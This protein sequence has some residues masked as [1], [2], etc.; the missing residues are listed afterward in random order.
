M[1]IRI[2]VVGLGRMGVVHAFHAR[3]IAAADSSFELAAVVDADAQRAAKMAGELG[4][5]HYFSSVENLAA[6]GVADAA[7]VATPTEMHRAHTQALIAAGMRVLLEKPLTESLDSD[8]SF[9][10]WLDQQAPDAVMLGFQRRF[11][12]PL[13]EA[14]KLIDEGAIGRPFKI[15]SVLEDSGPLPD[16][17]QS[18]GLLTDMA[19]HNVDEVRWLTG[20]TPERAAAIG[21]NLSSH[22]LTTAQEDHDEALLLLWFQQ[23]LAARIEVSRNHRPGYRIETQIFGEEGAVHVGRFR[24]NKLEVVLEAFGRERPLAREAHP[25]R[26]YENGMPEFVD[27][28]GAAY[29]AELAAFVECC[30][31][32]APFPV[33]HR[34]GLA[35]MQ[36]IEA[37][38]RGSLT[39][40]KID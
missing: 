31:E 29:Q 26:A 32:D 15:V 22:K 34:D 17:Y 30:R 10:A 40:A 8:R 28:Y 23:D 21:F 1:K 39:T 6:A 12:A 18:S 36:V 2:A 4:A 11:D 20:Q 3:E 14:K 5:P 16:G 9:A 13:I 35:A 19:V 7:V 27:R 38:G 37:A 24:Q 33:S 25:M